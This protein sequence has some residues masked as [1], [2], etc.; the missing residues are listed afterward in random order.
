[1]AYARGL[2]LVAGFIVREF[3][4]WNEIKKGHIHNNN[5]LFYIMADGD[6]LVFSVQHSL[7]FDAHVRHGNKRSM[8][9]F[10]LDMIYNVQQMP[11]QVFVRGK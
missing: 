1:M 5:A 8:S 9:A 11:I 3:I 4:D 6:C 7:L 10:S 2:G